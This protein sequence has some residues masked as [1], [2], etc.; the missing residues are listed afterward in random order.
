MLDVSMIRFLCMIQEL[1]HRSKIGIVPFSELKS[2]D[3]PYLIYDDKKPDDRNGDGVIYY[4][5]VLDCIVDAEHHDVVSTYN[6]LL[7]QPEYVGDYSVSVVRDTVTGEDLH[8]IVEVVD[9]DNNGYVSIYIAD[10]DWFQ[11][12]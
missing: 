5:V 10:G 3:R 1:A 7:R 9:E 8:C 11:D 12:M 4:P 6:D 2:T